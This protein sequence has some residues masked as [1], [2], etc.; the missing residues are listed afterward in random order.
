MKL[1]RQ[2]NSFGFREDAIAAL[3]Q[4]GYRYVEREGWTLFSAD[5][6]PERRAIV[7]FVRGRWILTTYSIS[8]DK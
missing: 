2:S 1:Q 6:R 7:E 8:K 4:R 5:G 3:S